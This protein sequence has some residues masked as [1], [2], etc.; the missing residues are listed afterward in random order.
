M[1]KNRL[2]KTDLVYN[3]L[4]LPILILLI[5]SIPPVFIVFIHMSAS[6][7]TKIAFKID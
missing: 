7:K 6:R 4:D 2:T 1:C 3:L 5:A